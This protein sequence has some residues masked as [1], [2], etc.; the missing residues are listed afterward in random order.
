MP[1]A[2]FMISFK[3]FAWQVAQ[4]TVI[5]G[6]AGSEGN[7]ELIWAALRRSLVQGGTGKKPLSF[8]ISF[9]DSPQGKKAVIMGNII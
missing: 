1:N 3:V 9:W 7:M 5:C 2:I 4:R 6:K 8:L